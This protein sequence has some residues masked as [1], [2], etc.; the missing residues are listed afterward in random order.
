[1][2]ASI[3]AS[4]LFVDI[5]SIKEYFTPNSDR[6]ISEPVTDLSGSFN[7]ADAPV[8]AHSQPDLAPIAQAVEETLLPPAHNYAQA[9]EFDAHGVEGLYQDTSGTIFY[10]DWIVPND[11]YEANI[12][13]A[14]ITGL[15]LSY[16]FA[17][18]AT[19]SA[20]EGVIDPNATN[21]MGTCGLNQ[22]VRSTLA[23]YA[24][25]YAELIGFDGIRDDLIMR[26]RTRLEEDLPNGDPAYHLSHDYA[27]P[28][29]RATVERICFDPHFNTRLGAIMKLLDIGRMQRNLA[30]LTPEGHD[31][32]P[33]TELQAYVALFAGRT[34]A[35]NMI[36]DLVNNNGSTDVTTFFSTRARENST[37]QWVLYHTRTVLDENGQPERNDDGEVIVVPDTSNPRT[38]AEFF[39]NLEETRPLTNAVLPNFTDWSSIREYIETNM[40]QLDRTTIRVSVPRPVPRPS[41]LGD[42]PSAT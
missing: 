32:F 28:L 19:E 39:A 40:A 16:M 6:A 36:E 9:T 3:A 35:E 11:V 20:V 18:Q 34:G 24:Y 37:N 31:F 30:E 17:A 7:G 10:Q 1:M 22:F 2:A 14:Q 33:V 12:L 38:V 5:G 27:D 41:N 25:N 4:A 26:T 21:T 13:T 23:E 42:T 8:I 15:P 29:S